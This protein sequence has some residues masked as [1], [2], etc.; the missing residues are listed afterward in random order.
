MRIDIAT[1]EINETT[2]GTL[3]FD[4]D[5]CRIHCVYGTVD[6]LLEERPESLED[7]EDMIRMMYAG[8]S[9]WNLGWIEVD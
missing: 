8:S 3:Q 6:E 2:R 7:A 4:T 1:I 5:E 9:A